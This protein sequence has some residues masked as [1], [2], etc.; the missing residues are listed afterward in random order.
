MNSEKCLKTR[1]EKFKD[2]SIEDLVEYIASLDYLEGPWM[3]LFDEKYC[4]NC[5]PIRCRYPE[6][7]VDINVAWCELNKKCKFFPHLETEPTLKDII[8][9]WLNSLD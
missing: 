9:L 3:K 4:K 8:R 5:D 6:S 1:F 7:L 2:M